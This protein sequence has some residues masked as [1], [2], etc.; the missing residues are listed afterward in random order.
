MV[1]S[2]ANLAGRRLANANIQT[3]NHARL[4]VGFFGQLTV[5][6]PGAAEVIITLYGVSR[7]VSIP[8][9]TEVPHRRQTATDTKPLFV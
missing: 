1:C 3:P 5:N 8:K 2:R 9:S 4:H 7:T 6:H